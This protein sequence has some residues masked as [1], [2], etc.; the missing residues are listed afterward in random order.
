MVPDDDTALKDKKLAFA[1]EV[2]P[3]D[4]TNLVDVEHVQSTVTKEEN[5]KVTL[6]LGVERDL[7]VGK[8]R[9]VGRGL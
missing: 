9:G 7:Q 2:I 8:A 4:D 1:Q 3:D 5:Q 6:G